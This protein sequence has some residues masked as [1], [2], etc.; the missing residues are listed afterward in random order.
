VSYKTAKTTQRPVSA[1]SLI[2]KFFLKKLERKIEKE[3][4]K[5]TQCVCTM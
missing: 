4:L 5:I 1:L 3:E 2:R